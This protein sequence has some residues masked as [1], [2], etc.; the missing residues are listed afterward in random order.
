MSRCD[1][2]QPWALV[3]RARSAIAELAV[4]AG[5]VKRSKARER[6]LNE[7]IGRDVGRSSGVMTKSRRGSIVMSVPAKQNVDNDERESASIYA[8][9]WARDAATDAADAALGAAAN[10]RRVLPAAPQ[11]KD[12]ELRLREPERFDGVM[13]ELRA[14]PA[15]DPV[16]V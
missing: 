13:Q 5:A 12:P 3:E 6:L 8:P 11:L 15:L 16:A 7:S 10:L 1:A 14:W 2:A 4:S 9:P